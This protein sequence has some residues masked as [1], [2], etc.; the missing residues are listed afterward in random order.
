MNELITALMASALS[1]TNLPAPKYEPVVKQES[2]EYIVEKACGSQDVCK[3]I[4]VY[5]DPL[6]GIIYVDSKVDFT[7][8]VAKGELMYELARHVLSSH[9]IYSVHNTCERNIEIEKALVRIRFDWIKKEVDMGNYKGYGL[10]QIN[11]LPTH[12]FYCTPP[13]N[14]LPRVDI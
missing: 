14:Q 8:T 4:H 7:F 6:D 5:S 3:D 11:D 12:I 10:P 9:N 2:Y 1:F 13:E